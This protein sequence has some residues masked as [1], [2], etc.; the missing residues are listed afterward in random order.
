[1]CTPVTILWNRNTRLGNLKKTSL[2]TLVTSE[3]QRRF[4]QRYVNTLPKYCRECPVLFACYGECPRNRFIKSPN[5]EDG[6]NYLC[7]GYQSF[8]THIN[9]PMN[10]M[11]SLLHQGHF[12][13]EIMTLHRNETEKKKMQ[14]NPEKSQ[15][16]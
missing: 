2:R 10:T 3:K 8:F 9:G 5:G 11:A 14:N 13:D 12:T 15:N 7:A 16:A 1:M 6:L 4:G